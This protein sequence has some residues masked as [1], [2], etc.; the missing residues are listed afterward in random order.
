[1]SN[2][3]GRIILLLGTQGA[4]KT[5]LLLSLAG[6]TSAPKWL[7]GYSASAPG[8]FCSKQHLLQSHLTARENLRLV[9]AWH[10][11]RDEAYLH[12]LLVRTNLLEDADTVRAGNLPR[13][14]LCYLTLLVT[15]L[16]DPDLVLVDDLAD[17]LSLPA[18]RQVW[19]WL[20]A[21]QKRRPRMIV[22]A[23]R[24]VEAARGFADEVWLWANGRITAQWAGS[25][26]PPALHDT[27]AFSFELKTM[28]AASRFQSQ[29]QQHA[30]T[31][32]IK[33]SQIPASSHTVTVVI[34]QKLANLTDLLGLGGRDVTNFALAPLEIEMLAPGIQESQLEMASANAPA[35]ALRT[36]KMRDKP[37]PQPLS[38]RQWLYACWQLAWSEWRHHFR[39]FWGVGNLLFSAVY[40]LLILRLL[41]PTLERNPV[42]FW[43][44][45][46]LALVFAAG[47][48]V[49]FTTAAVSRWA[50]TGT[51]E[52][53]FGRAGAPNRQ[54]PFSLLS[55]FDLSRAGRGLL[56]AGVCLG[57]LLVLLAHMGILIVFWPF[58]LSQL[59]PSWALAGASLAFWLLIA[60]NGTALAILLGLIGRPDWGIWLGWSGWFLY[61]LSLG[62]VPPPETAVLWLWPVTGLATAFAR[63]TQLSAAFI[64]FLLG[65]L[66]VVL[67][68][69]VA[70][71]RFQQWPALW[72]E[73]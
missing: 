48:S 53:L 39:R 28:A 32:A 45:G 64:P 42:T 63:A 15:L 14:A 21:E 19:Q 38:G 72:M 10:G 13:S 22:Y 50:K 36:L 57:Q 69:L 18:R 41:I 67:L 44:H 31:L 47:M 70:V 55:L 68:W 51:M 30:A 52:T 40:L 34:D 54:Q 60:L 8:A 26:L 7:P 46:S 5:N 3:H 62:S 56:L 23:T 9:A 61:V 35:H 27:A 49:G 65:C 37:Q 73:R 12:Q 20:H 66:G 58:L 2:S 29:M 6:L 25:A 43:T 17:G 59:Y 16:P 71:R 11:I 33:P 1:M 24:D 4:G